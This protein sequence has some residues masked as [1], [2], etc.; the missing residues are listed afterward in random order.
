M[1]NVEFQGLSLHY[2]TSGL[3]AG[4]WIVLAHALG[5]DLHMWDEVLPH[6]EYNFRVLRY[7]AKRR[8]R[9]T[10]GIGQFHLFGTQRFTPLSLGAIGK[11]AGAIIDSFH[12][13]EHGNG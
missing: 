4:P 7:D 11:F 2:E 5:A 1:P 3:T 9:T 6:L 8:T 13:K 12:R 10:F